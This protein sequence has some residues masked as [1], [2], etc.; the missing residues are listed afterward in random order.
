VTG[1]QTTLAVATAD[2]ERIREASRWCWDR[3]GLRD[4]PIRLLG[5]RVASLTAEEERELR[6]L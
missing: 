4:T 6:L 1:R 2:V 3:S 5:T